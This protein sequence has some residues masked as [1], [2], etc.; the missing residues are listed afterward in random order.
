MKLRHLLPL[1][2]LALSPLV[3][4]EEPSASDVCSTLKDAAQELAAEANEAQKELQKNKKADKAAKQEAK[5]QAAKTKKRVQLLR[6]LATRIMSIERGKL[7]IDKTD[8]KGRTTLMLAA[9]L[10]ERDAVEWLLAKGANGGLRNEAGKSAADLCGENKELAGFI[11]SQSPVTSYDD[12]I[13]LVDGRKEA[14]LLLEHLNALK[15]GAPLAEKAEPLFYALCLF[16]R[17]PK[18]ANLVLRIAEFVLTQEGLDL[19]ANSGILLRTAAAGGQPAVV[20]LLLEKGADPTLQAPDKDSFAYGGTPMLCATKGDILLFVNGAGG[21]AAAIAALLEQKAVL[22]DLE[23][24]PAKKA[25]ALRFAAAHGGLAVAKVL[26]ELNYT[27]EELSSAFERAAVSGHGDICNVLIKKGAISKEILNQSL[28]DAA[29]EQCFHSFGGT[30][31]GYVGAV[32][33]ILKQEGITQETKDNALG[34]AAFGGSA[35]MVRLLLDNGANPKTPCQLKYSNVNGKLPLE[36][37]ELSKSA[38]K[39]SLIK[40]A[41]EKK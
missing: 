33:L 11:R 25:T 34:A 6:T 36:L 16:F 17:D 26:A 38:G 10:G 28:I 39:V 21:H 29:D 15:G 2:L 30:S 9:S 14:K 24:N 32:A 13:T 4:A 37:A 1:L 7:P 18:D 5:K 41:L 40:T 12:A 23:K 35:D 20:R 22:D 8:K 3:A 31:E 19:N 27:E